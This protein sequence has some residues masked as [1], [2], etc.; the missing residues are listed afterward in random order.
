MIYKGNNYCGLCRR[1]RHTKDFTKS[2]SNFKITITNLF[3]VKTEK[4]NICLRKLQFPSIL[5]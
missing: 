2:C 5:K 1:L 3:S 4:L